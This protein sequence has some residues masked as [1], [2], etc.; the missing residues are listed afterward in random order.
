MTQQPLLDE[1]FLRAQWGGE[2][3]AFENSPAAAALLARLH[4]WTDRE[5]LKERSSEA[6]LI[7]RFFVETW[8]YEL[9]GEETPA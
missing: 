3:E 4:A 9:Y 5:Q 8:G 6:A 2:F 1:P 7:Q